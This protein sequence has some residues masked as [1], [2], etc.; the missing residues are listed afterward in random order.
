M[1]S[2]GVVAAAI[3]ATLVVVAPSKAD[4]QAFADPAGDNRFGRPG[5][6]LDISAV[7]AGHDYVRGADNRAGVLHHRVETYDEWPDSLIT[8]G[9]GHLSL[10]IQARHETFSVGVLAN[11]DGSLYG[12]IVTGGRDLEI[13]GFAR[14]WRTD[15]RSIDIELPQSVVDRGERPL[16]SYDWRV[17]T[18]DE[19]CSFQQSDVI[20]YCYDL[21]PDSGSHTHIVAECDDGVDNDEDDATDDADPACFWFGQPTEDRVFVDQKVTISKGRGE[22]V[23]RGRVAIPAVVDDQGRR[24]TVPFDDCREFWRVQIRGMRKG[25]LVEY[26]EATPDEDGRW[27]ATVRS[28]VRAWAELFPTAHY[29]DEPSGDLLTCEA[30][31]S[32]RSVRTP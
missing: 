9:P 19:R 15:S 3:V 22:G 8:E 26:G 21:S 30:A 6:A 20:T 14:A 10:V 11:P 1:R 23:V 17:Q 5:A 29:I 18:S 12:R 4:E 31:R 32:S 24:H 25:R 27:R 7:S 13:A 28:G 2:R 16:Y